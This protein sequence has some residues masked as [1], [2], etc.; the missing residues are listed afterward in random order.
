MCNKCPL[1]QN[2][3]MSTTSHYLAIII[4][5]ANEFKIYFVINGST[6]K[7]YEQQFYILMKKWPSKR[8]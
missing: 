4:L 6:E 1:W 8:N 7:N 5:L 2:D 3:S